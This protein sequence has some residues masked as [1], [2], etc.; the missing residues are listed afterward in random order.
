MTAQQLFPGIIS[1]GRRRGHAEVAGRAARLAGG[2]EGLGV[3]SGDSVCILMRND[4]AFIEAAYGAMQLGAYA[5]PVNWHFKPEEIH[6]I[7]SDSGTRVLVAHAD[8]LHQL[9][10]SIPE[11]VTVLS[12][13]TPPEILSHYKIDSDT[14]AA[15][16][17]AID[18]ESWLEQQQPYG[19][20]ARPQPANMIYTSGT[21]GHPKGVRRHAPTPEQS[22]SAER[23]RALIYGLRLGARALLPGP[24]YHSA[25]N[26][27]GLRAGRLGG[28]LVLMP[29]FEP[30]EFLRLVEAERIDTIFMVPTMFIRLMKLP[31][32]VRGKYDMSSLH[33]VIHAAAPCPAAVKRAMIEWWGPVIHEFYGSTESGAVTFANSEDALKKPGTVGKIA[34]GAELRFVGEDGKMLPQGEI[35]EIYSKI[36]GNPDFTYHNKPEKRAEIDRDGFITSGDIGYLDED[37]YV[38]ICDRK[39]DMVISGGVNI[40]PAEIEAALHAVPGVHDCA[41]FGIPDEEFGEALMA[42]VEPQAGVTLDIADIRTRLKTSLADYKVPKH[43]EIL[44]NLPREDSGKIFKR[45]LRDPYWERAGRRI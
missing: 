4:I 9:R 1:G 10:D 27:F 17:F 39:R 21:T 32:A 30:E 18:L 14:L 3:K 40:Y 43:I 7:L 22:A 35:G 41:V 33:H 44:K 13:P 15:P 45:R 19:G 31:E 26:S 6:Y 42:V 24:L 5:V 37:G 8:M 34:P 28:A 16:D 12:V 2:Y 23:M 25:P 36:A 11:G 38:F 29:R 20:P